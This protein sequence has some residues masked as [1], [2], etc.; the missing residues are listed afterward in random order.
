MD[1][2]APV[3]PPKTGGEIPLA[4]AVRA[5][6][7]RIVSF[8]AAGAAIPL[9]PERIPSM[10]HRT[11]FAAVALAVV[12]PALP[13]P[14]AGADKTP[15]IAVMSAIEPE[16]QALLHD[17]TQ[18]KEV[19]V[20]GTRFVTGK[21]AGKDVVLFLSGVSMVNAAMT[22]Q[23]A[24]DRFHV[25]AIVF[26]GIAGGVDPSLAIGDVIV[27]DQWASYLESTLARKTG[28]G[29]TPPAFASTP[30]PN[31]GMIFPTETEIT[32][33]GAVKA[34]KRFWFPVDAGLLKVA[35]GLADKAKLD[36]C[37]AKDQCLSHTPKVVVGG[38]GVSG[39]A[40]VDN[41]EFRDYAFKTFQARVLDME[42]AAV[43]QVSYGNGVP[44][45][46]FRSLSDLAGGGEGANEMKTFFGLASTNSARVVT[47]FL[48]AMR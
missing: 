10:K 37:A 6:V 18:Q 12:L 25:K 34:E 3:H 20:G 30:Y 26:S 8:A 15:R 31:F 17:T 42:S 16:W 11:L 44:F 14:A 46:A 36:T 23:Q 41:A 1:P 38:N 45:I 19:R 13:A 47:E 32:P 27:A 35:R 40:F 2:R 22:A 29:F 7:S 21:L 9:H 24:I 33:P 39:S 5:D 4:A 43:A 28:D 48:K